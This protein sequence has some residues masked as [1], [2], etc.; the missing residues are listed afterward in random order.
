VD[1]ALL[2]TATAGFTQGSL[3]SSLEDV[4][5]EPELQKKEKWPI[6]IATKHLVK[7]GERVWEV[8]RG[9]CQF[10]PSSAAAPDINMKVLSTAALQSFQ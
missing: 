3:Y 10:M 4:L 7:P 1:A 9:N 6:R 2:S 5:T 8:V